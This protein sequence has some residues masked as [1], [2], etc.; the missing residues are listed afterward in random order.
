MELLA[1]RTR[2]NS[3]VQRGRGRR[4]RAAS[5][6]TLRNVVRCAQQFNSGRFS[7][8]K[9]SFT[10]D[11]KSGQCQDFTTFWAWAA[12]GAFADDRQPLSMV[13]RRTATSTRLVCHPPRERQSA[14]GLKVSSTRI[15]GRQTPIRQSEDRFMLSSFIEH[16]IRVK[17]RWPDLPIIS[18]Y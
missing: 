14:L 8:W 15:Y 1:L 17:D 7:R 5:P 4:F 12:T 9:Q 16:Q 3:K 2:S 13:S 10:L 11:L 18:C 6:H